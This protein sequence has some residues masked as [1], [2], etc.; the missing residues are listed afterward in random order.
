MNLV[1]L[2]TVLGIY[3]AQEAQLKDGNAIF[4]LEFYIFSGGYSKGTIKKKAQADIPQG[5]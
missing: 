4:I 3:A 5:I 1:L 2:I